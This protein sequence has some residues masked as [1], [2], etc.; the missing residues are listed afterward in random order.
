M[1]CPPPRNLPDP[2]MEP[3]SLMS[4]VLEGGSSITSTTWEAPRWKPITLSSSFQ[5]SSVTQSC[6]TLCD[7]MDC[8]TPSL[9]SITNSRSLLRLM[10][11]ESLKP[12]NRLILS[13]SAMHTLCILFHISF[14]YELSQDIE[15]SSLYYIVGLC[16]QAPLLMGILQARIL[17]W[18]TKPSTGDLPD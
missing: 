4:P 14:H 15:Y 16:H 5:F 7:P 17:K 13:G 3:M 2:G 1:P 18:V 12:S 6:L 9:P 10:S 11:V 8:S